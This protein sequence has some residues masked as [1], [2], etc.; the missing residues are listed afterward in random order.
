M[1][2]EEE[3]RNFKLQYDAMQAQP[4]QRPQQQKKKPGGLRGIIGGALPLVGGAIGATL[5]SFVAPIAGTAAGGAAGSGAG[6]FLKQRLLGEDVNMGEVGKEAALGA[7]PGVF[8]GASAGIRGIRGMKGAREARALEEA[9]EVARTM[10]TTATLGRGAIGSTLTGQKA[11]IAQQAADAQQYN[12]LARQNISRLSNER[13][14]EGLPLPGGGVL[15]RPGKQPSF[16]SEGVELKPV[17]EVPTIPDRFAS[18]LNSS[19]KPVAPAAQTTEQAMLQMKPTIAQRAGRRLTES[20]SGLKAG[21]NVG[22][23]AQLDEQAQFMSKYTGTPRQQ[24]VAMEKDMS[25]LS[26]Q[27]DDI[28]TNT[29]VRVDGAR[30]GQRL[31]QAS[32]DLTD[33][34]FVDLDLTN[35]S[36]QKIIERYSGKFAQA[37][38]GKGVND[39]IKTLN[40]TATRAA[41]KLSNPNASPLTAQETAALALKRAGDDVLSEVTE[42]APLKKN[43]AQIFDATP[44][45]AR[46]GE[47]GIGL[48]FVSGV[49]IKAPVQAAK[50]IQSKAGAAL[51]GTPPPGAPP[52]QSG[53]PTGF[54]PYVK[55]AIQQGVT[56]AAVSPFLAQPEQEQQIEAE[57]PLLPPVD[58]ASTEEAPQNQGSAFDNG[59][60]VQKAYLRALQAG[61]KEAA[62]LILAGYE[63]FGGATKE[64]P[65]SAEASKVVSNAN[66][67]LQSL[68]ELQSIMEQDPSVRSKTLLPGRSMFGGA[69]ASILGTSSYDTAAR[70][71]ADVITRLR[72]GAALTE[73]EEKF[74]KSQLPQAFDP[75]ETV[76]QKMQMFQDLFSSVAG[77]TGTAGTDMQAATGV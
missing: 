13:A 20:G 71:I 22:D 47:K 48:P 27:V 59:E 9:N 46:A 16:A 62:Q 51:Q 25:D 41:D 44:Q 75:P 54:R 52:T 33:E 50:G 24:R 58:L 26:K 34:R 35:P 64:K 15:V 2:N 60:E 29:P 36:V 30:V 28:L 65:L 74:Y 77:R 68:A 6:A 66:S 32:T 42:I 73:S 38:D 45:V 11:M 19:T 55:P 61:D 67:G 3:L 17:P 1:F 72:T 4:K 63:K 39:V 7:V 69:G 56:R 23:A 70:N 31:Q 5:G 49:N 12:N 8:K 21:K 18:P 40:K 14:S 76:S 37:Q 43:M 53:V 10:N 57:E